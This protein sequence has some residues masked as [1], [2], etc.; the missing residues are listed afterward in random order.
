MSASATQNALVV[1]DSHADDKFYGIQ[2]N[3]PSYN[4]KLLGNSS[5]PPLI[6][7]KFKSVDGTECTERLQ[8]IFRI[9]MLTLRP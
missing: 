3:V 1:G 6:G 9:L 7:V 2:K 5:C 8:K 4:W